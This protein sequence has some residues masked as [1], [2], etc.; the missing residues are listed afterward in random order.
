MGGSIISSGADRPRLT[1]ARRRRSIS[2]NF[3]RGIHTSVEPALNA[4]DIL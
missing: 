4:V 1:V 2:T 3:S